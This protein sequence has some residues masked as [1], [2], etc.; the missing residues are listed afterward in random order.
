VSNVQIASDAVDGPTVLDESLTGSDVADGSLTGQDV[1]E[2]TLGRVPSAV[3]GGLGRTGT[4][5]VSCYLGD[6][7]VYITCAHVTVDLPAATRALVIARGRSERSSAYDGWGYCVLVTVPGGVVPNTAM[8]RGN[9]EDFPG[10]FMLVG[11]TPVLPAGPT[12]FAL[13]C[14]SQFGD[15]G[16][17]VNYASVTAI[18]LS[19]S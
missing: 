15:S 5:D 4:L 18:A 10:D 14:N 9:G 13:D 3:L 11:I 1:V 17:A 12:L 2:S 6:D 19:P 7:G 16:W 8:P